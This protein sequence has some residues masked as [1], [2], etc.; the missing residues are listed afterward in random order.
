MGNCGERP[1]KRKKNK[2]KKERES[3]IYKKGQ[4]KR[5]KNGNTTMKFRG[6]IY[7][8]QLV[9]PK[10]LSPTPLRRAPP[11]QSLELLLL[12]VPLYHSPSSPPLLHPRPIT[13]PPL[14]SPPHAFP[15]SSIPLVS[16]ILRMLKTL[17]LILEK[18][19]FE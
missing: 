15:S 10:S 17:R 18:N 6:L 4:K 16:S 1:K 14:P 5:E 9:Y 7:F 3:K 11:R 19:R 2:K 8:R 12:F 13:Q